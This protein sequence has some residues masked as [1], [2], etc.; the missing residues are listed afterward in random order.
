MWTILLVIGGAL[1]YLSVGVFLVN[2]ERLRHP[3][4]LEDFQIVVWIIGSPLAIAC[5]SFACLLRFGVRGLLKI[6]TFFSP[7]LST[8]KKAP[9]LKPEKEISIESPKEVIASHIIEENKKRWLEQRA[10]AEARRKELDS[11]PDA[12]IL[13][14]PRN[15]G[16][17]S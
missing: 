13:Q 5:Y 16:G 10:K 2:K 7:Y 6:A 11:R 12:K 15:P 14:F 3:L 9:E 4:D 17:V 1:I 8:K